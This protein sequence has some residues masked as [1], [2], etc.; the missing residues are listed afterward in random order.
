MRTLETRLSPDAAHVASLPGVAR[1]LAEGEGDRVLFLGNSFTQAGVDRDLVVDQLAR[2]GRRATVGLAYPD[3][4]S[5]IEWFYLFRQFF[6]RP[7]QVPDLVVVSFF[8]RNL[9]DSQWQFEE[10]QRIGRWYSSAGDTAEIVAGSGAGF[11]ELTELTLCRLSAAFAAR[12]HVQ[13]RLLRLLAPFYRHTAQ[14]VNQGFKEVR[15]RSHPR[16]SSFRLV[17]R[18][19]ELA[20]E[21]GAWLVFVAAPQPFSYPIEDGLLERIDSGGAIFVDARK[22]EGIFPGSFPDGLH[23]DRPGR[24]VYS[25]LLARGLAAGP[26]LRHSPDGV[27]DPSTEAPTWRRQHLHPM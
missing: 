12:Q 18:L 24:Q 23:L 16:V 4:T 1:Q 2:H 13:R 19:I 22:V 9:H 10:Y 21:H 27:Q 7:G 11:G 15:D 25:R 20:E 17:D 26:G 14:A 8:R 6:V 3:D 5:I